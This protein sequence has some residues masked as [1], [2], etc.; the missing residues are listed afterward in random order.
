MANDEGSENELSDA[1]VEALARELLHL[2]AEHEVAGAV[3]VGERVLGAVFRGNLDLFRSQDPTKP[4][5]VSRLAIAC[6]RSRSWITDR[7]LVAVQYPRYDEPFRDQ[8][9]LS[10][11]VALL[12]APEIERNQLLRQAAM[13]GLSAQAVGRLI[14]HL[15]DPDKKPEP[16]A[17]PSPFARVLDQEDKLVAAVERA[18]DPEE[19]ATLLDD[20]RRGKALFARLERM[21]VKP[22]PPQASRGKS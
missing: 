15:L 12:R 14:D 18:R 9:S 22:P 6:R 10:V 8:V 16:A 17:R 21:L 13:Q 4:G 5:S 11:H 1:A 3:R 7:V 2:D 20:V 19:R